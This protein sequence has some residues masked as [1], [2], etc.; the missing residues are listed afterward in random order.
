[1][2]GLDVLSSDWYLPQMC[3]GIFWV[4]LIYDISV[5]LYESLQKT[6]FNTRL[7]LEAAYQELHSTEATYR[8]IF[9]ISVEGIFK[10]TPDGRYIYGNPT[11]AR[12]FGYESSD[13]MM[14]KVTDISQQIYV[15]STR[16]DEFID[17]I[18][19]DGSVCATC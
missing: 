1:M 18:G 19:R 16:R 7:H 11:L 4:C 8:S 6:E 2:L 14:A 5:Y 9:E 13:E 10:S 17:L 12:I 15:D 3:L